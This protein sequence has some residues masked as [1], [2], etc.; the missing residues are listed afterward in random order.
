MLLGLGCGSQEHAAEPVHLAPGT[1]GVLFIGNSLTFH[2]DL[3]GTVAALARAAGGPALDVRAAT[4]PGGTL[5]GAWDEGR[6]RALVGAARW[7]AVV[8]Q[9]QSMRPLTDPD[10]ME[11][12]AVRFAEAARR[13]GARVVVYGTWP[14]RREPETGAA[15]EATFRRVARAAHAEVAP[16]GA[17]WARALQSD[18]SLALW[19][20]DGVHPTPAGT[21]LAACVLFATLTGQ[22]P[23]GL[24][25]R[26]VQATTDG[27]TR[28]A[29]ELDEGL[30]ARLQAFAAA[31]T[32][33]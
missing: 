31:E 29:V 10:A 27:V 7:S 3:P 33:R 6:A 24:S 5:E 32:G 17:A 2:N 13:R 26:T 14:D 12:A 23:V 28:H 4:I 25:A 21:Y 16:A 11:H 1:R 8:L 19:A 30:A 18:P 15:L 22:S 20:E 9:E